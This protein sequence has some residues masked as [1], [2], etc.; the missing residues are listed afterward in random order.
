MGLQ[1]N[2]NSGVMD[3]SKCMY[4]MRRAMCMFVFTLALCSRLAL[5][6]VVCCTFFFC[7]SRAKEANKRANN[8]LKCL[9]WRNTDVAGNSPSTYR[10]EVFD[11]AFGAET[12]GM[13]VSHPADRGQAGHLAPQLVLGLGGY[14]LRVWMMQIWSGYLE[15]AMSVLLVVNHFLT[16][17][18]LVRECLVQYGTLPLFWLQILRWWGQ[19]SE[20]F[21]CIHQPMVI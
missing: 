6:S 5:F 21:G 11:T 17:W 7:G 14:G 13:Q 3:F 18:I 12:P 9:R 10:G 1:I 20:W 4:V 2:E 8:V 19:S 16:P 15:G